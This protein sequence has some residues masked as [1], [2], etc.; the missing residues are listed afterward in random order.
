MVVCSRY[1]NTSLVRSKPLICSQPPLT[2]LQAAMPLKDMAT[3]TGT[4]GLL[5]YAGPVPVIAPVAEFKFRTMAGTIGISIGQAI[6]TS[7][8]K[9]KI[10]R[11]P[12]LSGFDT[13]PAALTESVRTLQR[14]PVMPLTINDSVYFD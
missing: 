10:N 12:D 9:R 7:I 6:Y 1:G 3:S 2:A 5:K 11:I 4:F 14:L 8:L 13:S